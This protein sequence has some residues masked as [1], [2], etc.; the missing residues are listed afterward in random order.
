MVEDTVP[1]SDLKREYDAA[2]KD[3]QVSHNKTTKEETKWEK[4]REIQKNTR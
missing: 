4:T 1:S 2:K 3:K